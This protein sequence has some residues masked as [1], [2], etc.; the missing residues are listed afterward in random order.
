MSIRKASEDSRLRPFL[1]PYFNANNYLNTIIEDNKSDECLREIVSCI[2]S[3]NTE[4]QSYI[5]QHHDDLMFGMQD[6]A[7]LADR[8][9][10]LS[11]SSEKLK[12]S[13]ERIK[14]KAL[15]THHVVHKKTIELR[16][17]HEANSLLKKL[18]QF[19]H[20]KSQ[21]DH[22]L[23]SSYSDNQKKNQDKSEDDIISE[24]LL[25]DIR[26]AATAARSVHEL[27]TLLFNE[28]DTALSKVSIVALEIPK[29]KKIGGALRAC[30]KE[31][32]LTALKERNQASLGAA[33]QVFFNL[34]TLDEM[35]L[36]A[37]DYIVTESIKFSRDAMNLHNLINDYPELDH[38]STS[39]SGFK[40]LQ[41][42]VQRLSALGRKSK[43]DT[44]RPLNA[45]NLTQQRVAMRDI[46]HNWAM[47]LYERALQINVLK[48]VVSKKEDPSTSRKFIDVLNESSTN[49]KQLRRGLLLDVFWEK[50]ASSFHKLL[51]ETYKEFPVASARLFPF[52]RRAALETVQSSRAVSNKN[53]EHLS[54][55][56]SSSSPSSAS[57]V[58]TIR[59]GKG[60]IRR[61]KKGIFGCRS[62]EENNQDKFNISRWGLD[63][64]GALPLSNGKLPNNLYSFKLEGRVLTRLDDQIEDSSMKLEGSMKLLGDSYLMNALTRMS[65]PVNQMFPELDGYAAVVPS[66]RD[67]MEFISVVELEL[68]SVL[69]EGDLSFLNQVCEV[70]LKAIHILLSKAEGMI[71]TGSDAEKMSAQNSFS[72]TSQQ[73]HNVQLVVLL[74]QLKVAFEAMPQRVLKVAKETP[75]SIVTLSRYPSSTNTINLTLQNLDTNQIDNFVTRCLRNLHDETSKLIDSLIYG[76]LVSISLRS[77]TAYVRSMLT[78]VLSEGI[79]NPVGGSQDEDNVECSKAVQILVTT[80]PSMIKSQIQCYPTSSI[81]SKCTEEFCLRIM[82]TY[83]TIASLLRPVTEKSRLRTAKDMA[84]LEVVLASAHPLDKQANA[85]TREFKAFR[86][87]LFCEESPSSHTPTKKTGNM[88]NDIPS[89]SKILEL[90]FVKD[91]RPS[92][93]LNHLGACAP[94][95]MPSPHVQSKKD[96]IRNY[97]ANLT[98]PSPI[99]TKINDKNIPSV[100][101][102]YQINNDGDV[103]VA[104]NEISSEIKAWEAISSCLDILMERTAVANDSESKASLRAW[105]ETLVEIGG[106]LLPRKE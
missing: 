88:K 70:A 72:R 12:R 95:Q 106:H 102:L 2:D 90:D 1:S 53:S 94:T 8:Y 62:W 20:I 23:D 105:Y 60:D 87:L 38:R 75:G 49:D 82:C 71:M 28:E 36:L 31:K 43:K 22:H 54:V 34:G 58:I 7:L 57:P 89:A 51:Q 68:S 47:Q 86:Q 19:V 18:R 26:Y 96:N 45:G 74:C 14:S 40:D 32:M 97:I 99:S 4:I 93:L 9:Q 11:I 83:T 44:L 46:C 48:R 66:K 64:I 6:V 37:I 29:L 77:M 42:S 16:R 24:T 92:T 3:T 61:S 100:K 76:E 63:A 50:F 79:I 103:T 56:S 5:S 84:A 21:L 80:I 78:D 30:A 39:G 25:T 35:I 98:I 91:I 104:W 67:L 17:I 27:E 33:L 81:I 85:V 52:L 41:S 69:I 65:A 101:S 13:V 15:E 10:K 55:S 73:E 59:G